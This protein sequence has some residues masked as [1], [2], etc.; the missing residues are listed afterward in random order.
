MVVIARRGTG[1]KLGTS[2]TTTQ[3]PDALPPSREGDRDYDQ[4]CPILKY[5][6]NAKLC[7]VSSTFPNIPESPSFYSKQHSAQQR[8]C[9]WPSMVSTILITRFTGP[10]TDVGDGE[11]G[12]WVK[13][14]GILGRNA[15][16]VPS[17][18][19]DRIKYKTCGPPF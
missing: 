5:P 12:M 1:H 11:L 13:L 19:H 14:R 7:L 18:T 17:P 8:A 15:W 6:Y 3:E 4:H 16:H 9:G 2:V 10:E